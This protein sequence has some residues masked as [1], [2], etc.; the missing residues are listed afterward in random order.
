M[1]HKRN[2]EGLRNSATKKKEQVLKR[3]ENAI[4]CLLKEGRPVNFKTVAEAGDLSIPYLYK[5][6]AIRERIEHLRKRLHSSVAV[7]SKVTASDDSKEAMLAA[8]REKIKEL[9][10]ENESLR[11]QIEVAYGLIYQQSNSGKVDQPT[12]DEL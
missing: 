3:A 10:K 11:R 1:T 9:R 6:Q 8:L 2:V 12:S 4:H 5:N 7:E